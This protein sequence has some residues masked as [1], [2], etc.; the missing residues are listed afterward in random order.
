M[1]RHDTGIPAYGDAV[2]SWPRWYAGPFTKNGL[3][4]IIHDWGGLQPNG[5]IK[6]KIWDEGELELTIEYYDGEQ[7]SL[8][9]EELM[10]ENHF[11]GTWYVFGTTAGRPDPNPE[12]HWDFLMPHLKEER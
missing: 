10:F 1:S 12:R 11:G 4:E 7:E 8:T 6:Q 2:Y 3:G 5:F 9:R